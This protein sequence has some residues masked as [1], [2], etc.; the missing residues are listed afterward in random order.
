MNANTVPPGIDNTD[1]M[2]RRTDALPRGVGQ[3]HGLFAARAENAQVWDVE[4][5]RYIDFVAGIAVVNT[6]HCHPKVVAAE[7]RQVP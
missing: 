3:A 4:G 1:M 6:G 7:Q 5:R 2:A